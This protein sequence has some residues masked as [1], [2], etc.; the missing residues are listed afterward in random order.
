MLSIKKKCT[1]CKKKKLLKEFSKHKRGSDGFYCWCKKCVSN[2]SLNYY[3]ENT[4]VCKKRIKKF[5]ENNP[6][7]MK[8]YNK[9]HKKRI[10]ASRKIYDKN[11]YNNDPIYKLK[12]LLRTRF[13]QS[14]KYGIKCESVLEIIGCSIEELKLWL[15]TQFLPEFTWD[16]YGNVWEIDHIKGCCNFDLSKISEQKKCWNYK[17]LRPLFST[18]KIAKSFGYDNIECNRSRKKFN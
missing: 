15:E 2:K 6:S 8:E 17:N 10:K 7:Y 4:K 18:K 14:I 13:Y 12:L 5:F 16:N 11:K 9:K 3:R 1:K